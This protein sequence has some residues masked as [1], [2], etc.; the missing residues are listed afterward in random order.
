MPHTPRLKNL[1]YTVIMIIIAV[2]R[3]IMF[4]SS[5]AILNALIGHMS[6]LLGDMMELAQGLANMPRSF[7][8]VFSYILS[9]VGYIVLIVVLNQFNN[10]LGYK[11]HTKPYG[12]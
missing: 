12:Y 10:S 11:N 1:S 9:T 5:R 7:N 6:L 4:L 2:F 3:T 8:F